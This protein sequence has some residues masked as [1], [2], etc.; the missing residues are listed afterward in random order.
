MKVG[1]C[2]NVHAGTSLEAVNQNLLTHAVQVR[3]EL[4]G[5]ASDESLP[6]GLWLSNQAAMELGES[7]LLRWRDWLAETRLLPYTFNGFPYS[8]F[9]QPVVKHNVYLPTWAERS[10]LDYTVKLAQVLDSILPAGEVGT[11]STLPLAWHPTNEKNDLTSQPGTASDSLLAR[12]ARQLKQLAVELDRILQTNG[13]LIK[14]G[15]EPEP[16]CVLD[17]ADDVVN[18]FQRYL[19]DGPDAERVR[20]HVGVC[21]DVCHSAVMF[22][23]QPTAINAYRNAGIEICKVQIS[24]AIEGVFN[25]QQ[26]EATW[27]ALQSFAEPKYLHQTSVRDADSGSTEFFEDLDLAIKQQNVGSA[28]ELP[29]NASSQSSTF[30]GQ[31]RVHFH[32]PIFMESLGILNTTQNEITECFTALNQT[33]DAD[34]TFSIPHFEVETY[35]WNVLPKQYQQASL[36]SGIAEEIKWVQKKV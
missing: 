12:S 7:Q 29:N 26:N 20:Q 5:S 34:Q 19:F 31:A 2:T 28:T 16:G 17:C 18:F 33:S 23:P 11:I 30:R 6:V 22:E 35:A 3:N 15:I 13:R 14:V 32:V 8:D 9:H 25:G 27:N 1:Y 21:H 10:R 36:A 24:S 4:L